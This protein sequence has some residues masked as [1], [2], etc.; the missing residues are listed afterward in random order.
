MKEGYKS[1]IKALGTKINELQK[2]IKRLWT[3]EEF[4]KSLMKENKELKKAL[5]IKGKVGRVVV[6]K[7]GMD[8]IL[9]LTQVTDTPNGLFVKGR[10]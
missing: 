6:T 1:I 9:Q 7:G 5:S 2:E 4:A 3:I 10:L 8:Y